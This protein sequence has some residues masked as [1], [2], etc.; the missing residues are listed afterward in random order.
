MAAIWSVAVVDRLRPL[1]QPRPIQVTTDVDT[2]YRDLVTG[3]WFWQ[4]A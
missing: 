1:N 2:I 4:R 3:E